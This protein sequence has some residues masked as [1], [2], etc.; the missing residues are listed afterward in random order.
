MNFLLSEML[1]H[2]HFVEELFWAPTRF[3]Q[4]PIAMFFRPRCS[5]WL[6]EITMYQLVMENN[7]SLQGEKQELKMFILSNSLNSANSLT[8]QTISQIHLTMTLPSSSWPAPWASV[9]G[10]APSASPPPPPTMTTR[11]PRSQ[12]GARSHQGAIS[13]TSY[14]K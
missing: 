1:T 13:Q 2:F 4:Q 8:I 3:W 14:R 10:S 12:A 11:W 9:T 6:L 7:P 5:R